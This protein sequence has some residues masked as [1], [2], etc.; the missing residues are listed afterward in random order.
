MQKLNRLNFFELAWDFCYLQIL[1]TS[2]K[3]ERILPSAFWFPITPPL[4]TIV[5][6]DK[7]RLIN[8]SRNHTSNNLK[9]IFNHGNVYIENL[10]F[11]F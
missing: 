2:F 11:A 6:R 10:P 7:K 8:A 1:S 4:V 5:K 9:T 3:I